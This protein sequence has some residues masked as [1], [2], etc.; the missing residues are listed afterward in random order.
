M[1]MHVLKRITAFLVAATLLGF[2]SL[3]AA[4]DKPAHNREIVHEK[5]KADKK[6]IVTKYMALTASEAK[7]FWPVYQAISGIFTRFRPTAARFTPG[8]CRRLS[9]QLAHR[10]KGPEAARRVDRH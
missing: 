2:V 6:S 5:L 8:L 3:S 4:Q 10:R 9:Q 1:H 7:K